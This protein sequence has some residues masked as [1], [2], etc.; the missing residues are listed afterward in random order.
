MLT[1]DLKTNR[2]VM[3]HLATGAGGA[4]TMTGMSQRLDSEQELVTCDSQGGWVAE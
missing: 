1:F 3:A 4:G 2:R